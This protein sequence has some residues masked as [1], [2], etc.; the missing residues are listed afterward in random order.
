MSP[1]RSSENIS[2]LISH[3]L[4][5]TSD[6][7]DSEHNKKYYSTIDNFSV[8]IHE[9]QFNMFVTINEITNANPLK[10]IS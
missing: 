7:E 4:L 2:Y 3:G 6:L 10:I 8:K 9:D 1:G 5:T